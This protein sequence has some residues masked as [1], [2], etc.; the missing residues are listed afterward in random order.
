MRFST[1]KAKKS[2]E[3]EYKTP[4][5]EKLSP[6]WY[7][8]QRMVSSLFDKDAEVTVSDLEELEDGNYAFT[9]ESTN[10][11][12]LEAIEKLVGREKI[13]GNI[14]VTINY[15][16]GEHEEDDWA[17][18]METAFEGNPLFK[19]MVVERDPTMHVA[20]YYAVFSRDIVSFWNDNLCDY[21][22]NEHYIAAELA[23]EVIGAK[24]A[25]NFCTEKER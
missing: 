15:K 19:E 21:A 12:K 13:L 1:I 24:G 8:Y 4:K 14:K 2:S 17:E 11:D 10:K 22:G 5:A 20:F 3:P 9:I 7:G 6:P 23:K 25:I 16:S 18:V